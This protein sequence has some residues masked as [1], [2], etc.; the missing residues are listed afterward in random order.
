MLGG[1]ARQVHTLSTAA[2]HVRNDESNQTG[3]KGRGM[4]QNQG[5]L[6]R[7]SSQREMD[8]GRGME[9]AERLG[10]KDARTL[11]EFCDDENQTASQRAL[12]CLALGYLRYPAAVPV[13]V[14][15]AS[16]LDLR[17]VN[18]ATRAL[19]MLRSELAVRPM[20]SLVQQERRVEVRNRAID[21]LGAIGDPRTE[22]LLV[23]ILTNVAEIES[24][25]CCAA[26]AIGG[27]REHS[28]TAIA[29]L[30]G[31]LG[32]RSPLLRWTAL[33]TLGIMGDVTVIPTIKP[34]LDDS[35]IVP[36][37]PS[38]TTVGSAAKNALKNLRV[39]RKPRGRDK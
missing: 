15:L 38:P 26:D 33:N 14:K 30:K 22:A 7:P 36:N 19:E 35:E 12:A 34:L 13:L 31:A 1:V 28:N 3:R 6:D 20:I 10:L 9:L 17:I 16:D 8:K 23:S 5:Q 2:I 29:S 4:R 39:C 32:E 18:D 11:L 24:T 25:R 37:L 27:L 21:V